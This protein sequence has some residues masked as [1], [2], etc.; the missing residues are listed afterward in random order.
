VGEFAV[1]SG[2]LLY[3]DHASGSRQDVSDLT[4][5]LKDVSLD[6]PV[7]LLLSASLN[8]MPVSVEGLIGPVGME[9][10][11][12]QLPVDLS[13]KAFQQVTLSLKGNVQDAMADPQFDLALGVEPFSPSKVVAAIGIP[14]PR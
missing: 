12:G 13:V 10:G 11:K 2:S 6:R 9:P 7:Q 14:F 8:K 1:R 4:L 5:E 3:L